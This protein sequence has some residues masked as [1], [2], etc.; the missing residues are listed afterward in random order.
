MSSPAT[1]SWPSVAGPNAALYLNL[2]GDEASVTV[3]YGRTGTVT[4]ALDRDGARQLA[5]IAATIRD[6]LAADA[7]SPGDFAA[8]QGRVVGRDGV[9]GAHARRLRTSST[10]AAPA[11]EVCVHNNRTGNYSVRFR[12]AAWEEITSLLV[13]YSDGEDVEER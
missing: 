12:R 7:P 11:A 6:V 3:T 5:A 8:A 9:V 2:V 10:P 1:R 13:R 4:V